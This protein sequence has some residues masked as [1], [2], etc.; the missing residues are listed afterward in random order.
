[1]ILLS[2]PF[3][4]S[5]LLH[6]F[7]PLLLV[8]SQICATPGPYIHFICCLH[9]VVI[10]PPWLWKQQ[11]A[12][13]ICYLIENCSVTSQKFVGIIKFVFLWLLDK[14]CTLQQTGTEIQNALYEKEENR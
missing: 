7:I 13:Q 10:H 11:V 9:R 5:A 8:Q 4:F 14:I 1:L 6:A 2:F 12:V 3:S